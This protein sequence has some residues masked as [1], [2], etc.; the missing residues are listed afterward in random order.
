MLEP[1]AKKLGQPFVIDNRP[2]ANGILATEGVMR[3]PKDGYTI[4]FT[5]AAAQ[6]VNQSLYPRVPYD[7]DKDFAAVAQI[8]SGG[9][10]LVVPAGTPA[11]DLK[12]LVAWVKAK[13]ADEV[14]YGSWGIGSGGHL[15]MEALIQRTGARMRHVPYKTTPAML[16]DMIG[17]HLSL[18]FSAVANAL[19]LI[20]SGKIRALGLQRAHAPPHAA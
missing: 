14:A 3:S 2:G 18:G 1:I 6:V 19:P 5:Y 20:K 15:S 17:G 10:L 7:G 9:N 8:G 12:E 13:P 11:K 16:T 4:L